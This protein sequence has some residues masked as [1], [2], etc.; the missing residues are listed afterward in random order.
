MIDP[1]IFVL[2]LAKDFFE[3]GYEGYINSLQFY[4]LLLLIYKDS[5]KRN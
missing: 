1:K 3:Y 2:K 5:L 4:S